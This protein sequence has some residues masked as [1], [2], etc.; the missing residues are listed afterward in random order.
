M[1]DPSETVHSTLSRLLSAELEI[2]GGLLQTLEQERHS[3]MQDDAAGIEGLTILKRQQLVCLAQRLGDRDR[4]LSGLGLPAGTQGTEQLV[5]TA[6]P[7]SPLAQLW[8]QLQNDARLL[9]DSN[10]RNGSI[11]VMAQQHTR[12]ALDILTGQTVQN[13][14]YGPSGQPRTGRPSQ[15]IAKV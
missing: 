15:A 2:T 5:R 3:L 13:R 9:Q 12:Q 4:L 7:D 6:V 11:L 14:T 10:E 1:I 8:Q